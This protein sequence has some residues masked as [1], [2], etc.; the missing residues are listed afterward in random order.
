MVDLKSNTV[1]EGAVFPASLGVWMVLYMFSGSWKFSHP[2]N[3]SMVQQVWFWVLLV[4][5]SSVVNR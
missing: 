1:L 2:T 3:T 4:V 5:W